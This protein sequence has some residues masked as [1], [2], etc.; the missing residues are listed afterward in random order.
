MRRNGPV[1]AEDREVN[2]DVE[3]HGVV[4][5][6][7][8]TVRVLMGSA[9]VDETA[10]R[11]PLRFD[12]DRPDLH[13]GKESRPSGRD[14]EG[15]AGQLGFGAGDHFCVGYQLGRAEMA[16]ATSALLERYADV[17]SA[18]GPAFTMPMALLR[19]VDRLQLALG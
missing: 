9:N 16:A 19:R 2:A 3:W 10:F 4:V 17:R 18:T 11:D 12:P 14:P 1:I 8:A 5:P 15:R 13:R 6:A 7:G